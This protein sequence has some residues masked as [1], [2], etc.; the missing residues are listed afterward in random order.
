M[1]FEMLEL[2]FSRKKPFLNPQERQKPLQLIF[3]A[4]TAFEKR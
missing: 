2:L 4:M 3:K 1:G